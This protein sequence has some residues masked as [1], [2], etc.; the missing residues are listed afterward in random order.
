MTRDQNDE[1]RSISPFPPLE[2]GEALLENAYTPPEY[3]GFGIM[4]A[5]MALIAE[6]GSE[7]D[8]RAVLTYVREDSGICVLFEAGEL[9]VRLRL[10]QGDRPRLSARLLPPAAR[11]PG[12]LSVEPRLGNQAVTGFERPKS[13]RGHAPTCRRSFIRPWTSAP[14][15]GG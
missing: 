11:A 3:R 2:S 14:S 10:G 15:K 8:A 5:A 13:R 9:L 7:R 4:S 1:I 6:R 12:G